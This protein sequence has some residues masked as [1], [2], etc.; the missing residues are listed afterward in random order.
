MEYSGFYDGDA[1]YGQEEFNKYFNELFESG[2]SV[3]DNYEPTFGVAAGSGEVVIDPG[4]AIVKGFYF[5]SPSEVTLSIASNPTSYSRIDRVVISMDR[6]TGPAEL[7]IL[8][9]VAAVSPVAPALTRTDVTW[10]LSLAQIV[11]A[12]GGSLTVVDERENISVCGLIRPRGYDTVRIE[13][14]TIIFGG[15]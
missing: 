12:P 3:D 4:Y 6:Q 11:V 10:E 5:D 8:Q 2:I 9:G 15:S 13:G 14:N 7:K 1:Y